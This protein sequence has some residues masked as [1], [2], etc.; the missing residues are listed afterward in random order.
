L[1]QHREAI[2]FGPGV[3]SRKQ[4]ALVQLD[5]Q[6]LFGDEQRKK[7][8]DQAGYQLAEDDL[9]VEHEVEYEVVRHQVQLARLQRVKLVRDHLARV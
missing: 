1:K 8:N 3:I 9:T 2:L 5:Q 6:K 7:K 4:P